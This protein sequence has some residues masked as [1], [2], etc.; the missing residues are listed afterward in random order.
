MISLYV[1]GI[2]MSVI[3]SRLFSRF[4]IK[5][6]TA[7]FVMELPPYRMP[8]WKAVFRHTWEKGKQY[9]KKIF[10]KPLKKRTKFFIT[11]H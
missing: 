7:P 2:V 10:L 4:L 8:T 3:M 6:E 1:I 5:D 9:L 11:F